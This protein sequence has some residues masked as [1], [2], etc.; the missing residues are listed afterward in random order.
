MTRP[1]APEKKVALQFVVVTKGK[2]PAVESHVVPFDERRIARTLRI[3]ERTWRAID[4]GHFY[5][6]PS[7]MSCPGCSFRAA[8]RAWAG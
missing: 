2:E 3:V 7:P 4:A 5:P 6:S 8:C 1:M